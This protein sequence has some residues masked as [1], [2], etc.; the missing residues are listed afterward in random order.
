MSENQRRIILPHMTLLEIV[1][2]HPETEAVFKRYDRKAGVCLCCVALFDPL[3]SAASDH[4]LSLAELL[5]DLEA[6][7]RTKNG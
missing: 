6:A 4:G 1:S 5:A 3:V 7:V 2:A